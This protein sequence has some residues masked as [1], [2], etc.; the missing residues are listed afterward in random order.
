MDEVYDPWP[1]K[2][3]AAKKD[4]LASLASSERLS[5]SR[6]RQPD[7][8]IAALNLRLACVRSRL[9]RAKLSM[10][11]VVERDRQYLLAAAKR[12][13]VTD[14]AE[15]LQT[16]KNHDVVIDLLERHKHL[17]GRIV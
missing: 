3:T 13:G 9:A 17:I 7:P 8:R 4:A 6:R 11:L 5:V 1:N 12:F 16:E 10:A 15:R 14:L 2:K